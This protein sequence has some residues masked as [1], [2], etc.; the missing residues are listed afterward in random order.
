MT[1]TGTCA[2]DSI[3]INTTCGDAVNGQRMT[4]WL[5]VQGGGAKL[6]DHCSQCPDGDA[7]WQMVVSIFLN[8]ITDNV[9]TGSPRAAALQYKAKDEPR[10]SPR[11]KEYKVM[12]NL[13]TSVSA[14]ILQCWQH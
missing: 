12:A 11:P 2:P 1:A 13:A 8:H 9:F 5:S 4:A 7:S 6:D 3:A 14:A 10:G